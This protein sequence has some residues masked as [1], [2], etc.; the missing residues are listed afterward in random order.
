MEL[1]NYLHGEPVHY[2]PVHD[3]DPLTCDQ[4]SADAT[5][6]VEKCFVRM[7]FD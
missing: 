5:E 2:E 1:Y 6:I 3:F 7:I 4:H